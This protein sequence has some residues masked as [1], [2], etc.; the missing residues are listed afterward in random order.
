MKQTSRAQIPYRG[1]RRR[2]GYVLLLTLLAIALSSLVLIGFAELSL[3]HA[4]ESNMVQDDLQ[5]KWGAVSIQRVGFDEARNILQ[6][7]DTET[8]T[9]Y[10]I[11]NSFTTIELGGKTFE[12]LL[13]DES[14][15]ADINLILDLRSEQETES[16]VEELSNNSRLEV[17]IRPFEN[18]RIAI[19]D[20][21]ECW[22]QVFRNRGEPVT[23]VETMASTRFLTCWSPRLNYQTAPDDVLLQVVSVVA[24]PAAGNQMVSQREKSPELS[25]EEA[26][27]QINLGSD[28][29]AKLR[30]LLVKNSHSQSLWIRCIDAKSETYWLGVSESI[31]GSIRRYSAFRW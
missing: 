1:P 2:R 3:N 29:K 10:P 13:A 14:S 18:P 6:P 19:E 8:E 9:T 28:S 5:R 21:I 31:S 24:G 20:D 11:A 4:I 26:I 30:Q 7:F 15:K 12:A 16:I 17:D 22:A 23:P 25:P 27:E